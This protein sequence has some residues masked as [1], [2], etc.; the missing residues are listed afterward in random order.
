MSGCRSAVNRDKISLHGPVVMVHAD[1]AEP[2]LWSV[3]MVIRPYL[4]PH[5]GTIERSTT[6]INGLYRGKE[7]LRV[8]SLLARAVAGALAP[9]KRHVV[10]N[11]GG[12]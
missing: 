5:Q 11:P 8:T 6:N 2:I 3:A 12:G 10:I 1:F 7:L 4:L 9:A